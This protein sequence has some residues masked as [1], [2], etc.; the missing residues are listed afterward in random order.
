MATTALKLLAGLLRSNS[1]EILV[2][3]EPWQC[4]RLERISALIEAPALYGNLTATE[5]LLAHT[6][7]LGLPRE[8]ITEAL[9]T[10]AWL[11]PFPSGQ[12]NSHL[13]VVLVP[14]KG[15]PVRQ[16]ADQRHRGQDYVDVL[17]QEMQPRYIDQKGKEPGADKQ[18]KKSGTV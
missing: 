10:A 4:R 8:R 13:N 14:D 16:Q 11:I 3:G 5:N 12:R 1:G 9:A 17:Q 6:R 18:H 7:L 2:F 15:E